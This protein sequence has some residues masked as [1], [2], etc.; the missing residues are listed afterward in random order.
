MWPWALAAGSALLGMDQARQQQKQ[1]KAQ[2]LAA[3]AQTEYS[4]W[5]KMGPGQIQTGGASPLAAGLQGGLTGFMQ[6]K[7]IESGMAA[8]AAAA[9]PTPGYSGS[10]DDIQQKNM[11]DE[12]FKKKNTLYG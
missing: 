5:T 7:A 8:D 2:N 10:F 4:P 11:Q 3:A 1:Q 6:G 12:L 9:K